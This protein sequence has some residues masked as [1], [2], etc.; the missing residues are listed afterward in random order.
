MSSRRAGML[1]RAYF[2]F[3]VNYRA[4]PYVYAVL[5]W[6][7]GC[8]VPFIVR[9]FYTLH[10]LIKLDTRD[11]SNHTF[12]IRTVKLLMV[13]FYVKYSTVT[14]GTKLIRVFYCNMKEVTRISLFAP[15][16]LI[17]SHRSLCEIYCFS[18][19]PCFFSNTYVLYTI[20]KGF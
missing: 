15:E 9:R 3:E 19:C 16:Q 2:S 18:P 20:R 13:S 4:T 11:N 5:R 8:I 7:W 10:F 1:Y 6:R 17:M 14:K 12:M